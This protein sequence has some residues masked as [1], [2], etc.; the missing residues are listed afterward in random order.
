MYFYLGKNLKKSNDESIRLK[1]Y[2]RKI[3]HPLKTKEAFLLIIKEC[4]KSESL[5][6]ITKFKY[7]KLRS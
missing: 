5:K 1:I 7:I 3:R 2:I 4:I 6:K